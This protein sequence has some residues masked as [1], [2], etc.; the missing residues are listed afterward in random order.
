MNASASRGLVAGFIAAASF[1]VWFLL[2]DVVQGQPLATPA[3]M[4]GLVFSFTTALPATARLIVFTILHF[5]AFGIVGALVAVLLDRWNMQPRLLLGIALGFLLFDIVFYGSVVALGVNVVSALGW[6][7]VLTAN[8]IAGVVLFG[9][10]RIRE[11]LPLLTLREQLAQRARLRRGIIAGVIGAAIVAAWF[12]IVD[13]AQGRLFY[14]PAALGSALLFGASSADAVTISPGVILAYTVVHFVA[15]IG[16]GLLVEWLL[17]E[18]E[19]HAGILVSAILYIAVLEVTSIGLISLIASWLL[20]AIPWW[21]PIVANLLAG[22]GMIAYL[23]RA[24]PGLRATLS[25]PLG[26]DLSREVV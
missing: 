16:V 15:F 26:E 21:S 5:L 17:N 22:A 3:Y 23:L 8:I 7:Q 19:Q 18:A 25:R 14:T 12:L 9:Y 2:V 13:L 6:P 10:L 11:G 1:A 20:E 24:H 4:S